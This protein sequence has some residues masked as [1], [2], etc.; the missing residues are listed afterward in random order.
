MADGEDKQKI[1]VDTRLPGPAF[2][3]L[4]VTVGCIGG[5]FSGIGFTIV[6]CIL[7]AVLTHGHIYIT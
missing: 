1:S 4:V 2:I 5:F 7:Y 6:F 3:A